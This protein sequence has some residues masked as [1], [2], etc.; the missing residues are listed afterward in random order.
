M[1][2]WY[3]CDGSTLSTSPLLMTTNGPKL[4]IAR[5]DDRRS[6]PSGETFLEPL[7]AMDILLLLRIQLPLLLLL[8]LLLGTLFYDRQKW[9]LY[10]YLKHYRDNVSVFIL[11]VWRY[12]AYHNQHNNR[13][14]L[15]FRRDESVLVLPAEL[16]RKSN[17]S[18]IVQDIQ[19]STVVT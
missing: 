13:F 8:L 14:V 18:I 3:S 5:T 1:I 15:K 6:I 12:Y 11:S 4:V 7:G 17:A 10:P 2:D 19:A 9:Y 16:F